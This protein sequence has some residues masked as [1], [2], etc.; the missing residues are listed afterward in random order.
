[1]DLAISFLASAAVGRD[2]IANGLCLFC[3]VSLRLVKPVNY[4][5]Q[6]EDA[7]CQSTQP[8]PGVGC[9]KRLGSL[10]LLDE[11]IRGF[12]R[13]GRGISCPLRRGGVGAPVVVTALRGGGVRCRCGASE[14]CLRFSLTGSLVVTR[15]TRCVT[16]G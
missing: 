4:H 5:A 14:I 1:M 2:I 7:R 10:T 16:P 12:G 15:F 11:R 9:S 8:I 3:R 13:S 6:K